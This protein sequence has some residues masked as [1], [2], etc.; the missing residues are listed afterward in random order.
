[1]EY[2]KSEHQQEHINELTGISFAEFR[3]IKNPNSHSRLLS[4]TIK[5]LI[6]CEIGLSLLIIWM[7]LYVSRNPRLIDYILI[8]FFFACVMRGGWSIRAFFLRKKFISRLLT[9][10]RRI[11]LDP[12]G[13]IFVSPS[14]RIIVNWKSIQAV[15]VF[16]Y[17]VAFIPRD[18]HTTL[19]TA[20]VENLENV[21]AFLSENN[22]DIPVIK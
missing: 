9:E 6:M 7:L 2:K 15:R 8:L 12:E 20:P 4:D 21:T 14:Q 18:H 1:M 3:F 13:V 5:M 22:I 10:E 16:K 19:I 11:D 17:A